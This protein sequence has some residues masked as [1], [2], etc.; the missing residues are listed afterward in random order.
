MGKKDVTVENAVP[1][2]ETVKM[3]NYEVFVQGGF[4]IPIQSDNEEFAKGLAVGR[5]NAK[6]PEFIITGIESRLAKK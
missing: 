6:L 2:N 1:E 4:K 3:N 5:I